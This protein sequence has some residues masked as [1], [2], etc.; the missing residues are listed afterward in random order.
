ME[1]YH[2]RYILKLAQYLHFSQ[3]A[4]K[5]NITQPSLSQGLL[6]VE[7]ELGVKLFER[8]T[9]S[10]RLTPAGEEFARQAEKVLA[11]MDQ[12]YEGMQRHAAQKKATLRIGTLLNMAR[13]DLNAQVLSFQKDNPHSRI[14]INEVLGSIELIRQLEAEIFDLVFFMPSPEMK[15]ADHL[16]AEPVLDGRAVA[17]VPH[18]HRLAAMAAVNIADLAEES[19]IFPAESHSL[20]GILMSVCRD[21]GFKPKITAQNSQVDTG[22][23]MAAQGIGIALVSSQFVGPTAGRGVEVKPLEPLIPRTI[24]LAYSRQ[25]KKLREIQLFRDFIL[26]TACKTPPA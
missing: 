9:R 3:T 12:L 26:R 23:E 18:C 5:L 24:C 19:L 25:T 11:A 1:L 13:L 17:I 2:L 22:V 6:Q 16:K 21:A 8:K 7:Q 20:F 14:L 10:V 4:A 15:L